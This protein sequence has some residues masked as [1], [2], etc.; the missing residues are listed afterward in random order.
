MNPIGFTPG[1]LAV[2]TLCLTPLAQHRAYNHC[3]AVFGISPYLKDAKALLDELSDLPISSTSQL[4]LE[5]LLQFLQFL[6]LLLEA[7]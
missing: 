5:L 3:S 6:L 7:H 4:L 1:M 2:A